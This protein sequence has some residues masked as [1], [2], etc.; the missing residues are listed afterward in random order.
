MDEIL[1]QANPFRV[2]LELKATKYVT[3]IVSK[4][5]A[6]QEENRGEVTSTNLS[7]IEKYSKVFRTADKRNTIFN[8][9]PSAKCVF[10]YM[11]YSVDETKDYI[12]MNVEIAKSKIGI[13][14]KTF[15]EAVKELAAN[16]ILTSVTG[17]KEYYWINPAFFFHGSRF[18]KYPECVKQVY[19]YKTYLR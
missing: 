2:S 6:S 3:S 13:S 7:E 18:N 1:E 16:K 17:I 19:E 4:Q 10:L 5:E 12:R 8:L 15:R 14:E 9:N 11:V